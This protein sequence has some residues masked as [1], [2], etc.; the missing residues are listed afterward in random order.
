MS[1]FYHAATRSFFNTVTHSVKSIPADAVEISRDLHA[2]LLEG[3][4]AGKTIR[5]N[6]DGQPE[7]VETEVDPQA[8][9]MLERAWRDAEIVR[10]T[11]LRD[12]HRD[13]IELGAPTTITGEQYS[14]LLA[15][16]QALR[17]WP[18]HSDFPDTLTRPA[19]PTWIAGA[20]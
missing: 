18:A 9:L 5:I 2:Y 4:A 8:K 13:E 12:R 17:D 11:W 20:F 7:L 14:E 1:I 16:I 10:V 6:V 15:Y 19:A 3:E